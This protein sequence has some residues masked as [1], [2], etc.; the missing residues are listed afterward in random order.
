MDCQN[1][2]VRVATM[3]DGCGSNGSNVQNVAIVKMLHI[4]AIAVGK[5]DYN[6]YI[7]N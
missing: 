4:A 5:A 2:N 6:V 3:L 7:N 1:T